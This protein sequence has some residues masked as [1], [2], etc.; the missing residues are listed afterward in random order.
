MKWVFDNKPSDVFWCTA[1]VGWVTGHSYIAYG[2]L[3]VGATEVV[4]E[5]VPVYPD[6][7]RFWKIIQDHKVN[8]FYTAPT[9][10]RSLI[11]AGGDL[12]KKYDLSS[13][14]ILGTVGEPINPEAWMWYHETV[15]GGR[16]PIVDTWWQTETGGHLI[17]PLPGATP[18]KPGSATLP[19]PGHLRRHRRRD[20]PFGRPRQGR[21]P[22]DHA[23]LAVDAAHDLGRSRALQEDLLARRLQE[24]AVPRRRWREHG[25]GGLLPHRR[26]HRRRAQ[27]LRPPP[28]HD[29]GRIGAGGATRSWSPRPRWSASPTS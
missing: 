22:G 24:Q 5:G 14:R 29:G 10:I 13:L 1:D 6:A 18:T 2:P 16:C 21:H 28:R 15:G 9:A 26:A 25:R 27:R 20:R 19:L 11:K 8:V 4:F 23:S 12:P 17:S 3:A 7:G